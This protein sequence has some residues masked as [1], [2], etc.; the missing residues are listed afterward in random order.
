MRIVDVWIR[1]KLLVVSG[2][3]SGSSNYHIA[4]TTLEYQVMEHY[5]AH[6][7]TTVLRLMHFYVDPY[8]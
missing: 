2:C 4:M 6:N 8:I 7:R 1:N 5:H 3:A